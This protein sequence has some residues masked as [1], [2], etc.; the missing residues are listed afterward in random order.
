MNEELK[1]AV[2]RIVDPKGWEVR[3]FNLRCEA[4][5]L[6]WNTMEGVRQA[7]GFRREAD[8]A[9]ADSLTK[10]AAILSLIASEGGEEGKWRDIESAPFD[11]TPV[12]LWGS[13]GRWTSA[14]WK[15]GHPGKWVRFSHGKG[16][17]PVFHSRAESEFTHW[18][19]IPAGPDLPTS[20]EG[21]DVG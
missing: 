10:A 5:R 7:P 9:V 6:A 21:Q 1:E 15:D 8:K 12:D 19:P 2:A 20:R 14:R 16:R 4:V 3:E 17:V 13:H 18:M 11:G